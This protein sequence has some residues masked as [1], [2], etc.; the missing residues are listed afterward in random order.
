MRTVLSVP[1]LPCQW[2]CSLRRPLSS[3]E[4]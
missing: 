1:S 3:S 2:T 4:L